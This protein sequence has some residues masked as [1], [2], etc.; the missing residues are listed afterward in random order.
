MVDGRHSTRRA[1]KEGQA[2]LVSK[3]DADAA[4][5]PPR[6][7]NA[8]SRQSRKVST[9]AGVSKPTK[10]NRKV[11]VVA[12][13]I[14]NASQVDEPPLPTTNVCAT[15][16]HGPDG[17]LSISNWTAIVLE[18]EDTQPE[19]EPTSA[20]TGPA[21]PVREHLSAEEVERIR[22]RVKDELAVDRISPVRHDF[23]QK[24]SNS[25]LVLPKPVH[26]DPPRPGIAPVSPYLRAIGRTPSPQ[27]PPRPINIPTVP[28]LS[29]EEIFQPLD[30]P[31]PPPNT[32]RQDY[33]N[34]DQ[35]DFASLFEE[36][37]VSSRPT[38]TAA[39]AHC[40][41]PQPSQPSARPSL[42]LPKLS[43]QPEISG[44]AP[45]ILGVSKP[46]I[47]SN[48]PGLGTNIPSPSW[49]FNSLNSST[50]KTEREDSPTDPAFI[51]TTFGDDNQATEDSAEPEDDRSHIAIDGHSERT[52]TTPYDH[53]DTDD[54]DH[55]GSLPA[56]QLSPTIVE[57]IAAS[58]TRP[59]PEPSG[60]LRSTEPKSD[61]DEFRERD[62]G[63]SP[64]IYSP[65]DEDEMN[66]DDRTAGPSTSTTTGTTA[67]NTAPPG[68]RID[69]STLT[70]LQAVNYEYR[71]K[72]EDGNTI[73]D[74][75]GGN[76]GENMDFEEAR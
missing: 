48:L 40:T 72:D 52:S 8:K 69:P 61:N 55:H 32:A 33:T 9:A 38:T 57:D 41:A 63:G 18:N 60:S 31:V 62:E 54:T 28:P 45:S 67:T 73:I 14:A 29:R 19:Y 36:E 44:Y 37:H 22:A 15:W 39:Q 51:P 30:A 12:K 26:P 47:H 27:P 35:D 13:R 17:D 76:V 46:H 65:S 53:N 34:T 11:S 1:V 74:S 56:A 2:S 24:Q 20:Y 6:I 5:S 68:P 66:D 58:I 23:T 42:A 16:S 10:Q 64:I 71:Q 7:K 4:A 70:G 3:A 59:G 50:G 43:P 49:N 25:S 21:A 75:D